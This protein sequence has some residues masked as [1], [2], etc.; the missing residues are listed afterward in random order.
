MGRTR[1]TQSRSSSRTTRRG[2]LQEGGTIE[3]V[4]ERIRSTPLEGAIQ[5]LNPQSTFVVATYWWGRGNNNQNLQSPCPEDIRAKAVARVLKEA[6][7]R[8]PPPAGAFE[9][10]ARLNAA[11]ERRTLIEKERAILDGVTKAL[12]IWK[13]EALSSDAARQ[14][15]RELYD[16]EIQ[17][18]RTTDTFKPPRKFEEM[19]AEWERT[20]RAANVNFV[21]LNTEFDRTDYQNGINGKPLFIKKV[22]DAVAPRGVLYIDGDMW[23]RT[24]PHIFDLP[25]V[26]FM[27]RGWNTDPRAKEKALKKPFYDPYTFETSGGTMYFGNT[28]TARKL[29]DA[30]S[31]ASAQQPGKAD[32]RIL[33]QLFTTRAMIAEVNLVNLPIEYLWLTDLYKTYLPGTSGAARIEDALIE[34]P[35]CLTGEE[36]A[37][38]QSGAGASTSRTPKNYTAEVEENTTYN[39]PPELFYEHIVFNGNA[40]MQA[41]FA[42]YLRYMQ[43]AVNA[44]TNQPMLTIIPLASRYGDY[45]AIATRNLAAVV[46]SPAAGPVTLP[47]TATIPQILSALVSGSD[48]TLGAPLADLRPETEFAAVNASTPQDAVDGYTRRVRID[49]AAPMFLSSKSAMVKHLLTMCETL[50]DINTHVGSYTF[51]S[52]IR[53]QFTEPV[54]PPVPAAFPTQEGRDFKPVVHQIWFGR[55]PEPWRAAMF[56]ANKDICTK[57]GFAYKLWQNQDRTEE[58]F[59][60]TFAL[61]NQALE[62]GKE[63]G[64]NRLAQV[65]DLAR[66][67]IVYN[68]SGIYAD[69][70]IELSPALLKAVVEAINGGADFVGCN[71]DTC[72]PPLDCRN[73]QG[74]MYLANSFFAATRA[75]PIFQRLLSP[76]RLEAIDLQNTEINHTTGPYFLRTGITP[77]DRVFLFESKQ[78]YPFKSQPSAY[79]PATPNRFLTREPVPG[80]IKVNEGMY[81]LPGGTAV[82]QTEFLVANRGPLAT[83]HSGLG[84]TWST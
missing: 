16:Q 80:S 50:A 2:R 55:E 22:L 24:Y 27:A 69:S 13:K 29:L 14:R 46:Q 35:Y 53:W 17:A 72:D 21:A 48:V 31:A 73:A 78:I 52:R 68:S 63:I 41:Q 28:A 62:V 75:N 11:Q 56:K 61:Q 76:E 51:L 82:L 44:Y 71:E 64:Q 30:W 77:E 70:L 3:S 19:I 32:D 15:V 79:A 84:G 12:E 9:I 8:T 54:A 1:R 18:L 65:A 36:R 81:Y 10:A 4:E 60:Q 37:K 42:P 43:T 39:R 23:I 83:Y 25:N 49:P 74:E 66:L 7:R 38:D 45:D 47:L 57:H 5:I 59:P 58:N 20:C 33:S 34:H 26:D 40:E 67:E 6:S